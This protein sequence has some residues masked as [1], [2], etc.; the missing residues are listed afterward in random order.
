MDART[1]TAFRMKFQSKPLVEISEA[2]GF[3]VST[4]ATYFS[5][6]GAWRDTYDEWALKEAEAV[7]KTARQILQGQV[8]AASQ[9]MADILERAIEVVTDLR[10]KWREAVKGQDQKQAV[11]YEDELLSAENR[12]MDIAQKILD[13]A[14]MSPLI[15]TKDETPVLP[16]GTATDDV[17]QR[18]RDAGID[19]ASIRFIDPAPP[20]TEGSLPN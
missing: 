18:L 3:T 6:D 11:V 8:D 19:P 15:R 13:R 9:V 2:T 17:R 4:L 5:V 20:R 12:A 14:G 16:L 10:K 1:I 7:Q